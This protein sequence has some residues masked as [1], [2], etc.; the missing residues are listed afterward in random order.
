MKLASVAVSVAAAGAVVG[1]FPSRSQEFACTVTAD[2]ASGRVC[3]SGLCVLGSSDAAIDAD[4]MCEM[5]QSPHVMGCM[6]PPAGDALDLEMAGTYTYNTDLAS[7]RAPDGSTLTPPNKLTTDGNQLISIQALTVGSGATLRVIGSHPMIVASWSTITVGGTIDIGSTVPATG[8]DPVTVT[9]AGSNPTECATHAAVAT[10]NDTN[11]AGGAGGGGYAGPG[12]HGGRGHSQNNFGAGGA[13][14]TPPLFLGGCSGAKGGDGHQAGGLGG[15]GGGGIQLTAQT[16]ITITGTINAG[17]AG[18]FA[19]TSAGG[20]AEGGGGGGGSGGMIG[21]DAPTVMVAAT[22][23]LAAN[24]GGGGAGAE[25]SS[26]TSGGS[27]TAS[28]TS[29]LGGSGNNS[30]DGGKG[31]AGTT[32]L[33]GGNGVDSPNHGG[34]GGGGGAGFVVVHTGGMTITPGAILSPNVTMM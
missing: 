10:A 22:A 15:A 25:Q 24:G 32:S 4:T 34:G 23:I 31:S 7:L 6:I 16:S 19:A 21:L 5:F 27:G 13:A 29:A 9:G 33:L 30:G 12:G 20:D 17:G 1:C 2:C 18:G 28:T 11:G 14:V 3:Q 8:I 26:A